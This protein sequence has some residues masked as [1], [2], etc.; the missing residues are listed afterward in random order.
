LLCLRSVRLVCEAADTGGDTADEANRAEA[1]QTDSPASVTS[2]PIQL[3]DP[4]DQFSLGSTDGEDTPEDEGTPHSQSDSAKCEPSTTRLTRSST[5]AR[6]EKTVSD[7]FELLKD[8]GGYVAP[9]LVLV[10]AQ[11]PPAADVL[12]TCLYAREFQRIFAGR[13]RRLNRLQPVP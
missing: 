3:P 13:P 1:E 7:A 10:P 11:V 9:L 8:I 5:I 6:W 4:V 2:E 12:Q